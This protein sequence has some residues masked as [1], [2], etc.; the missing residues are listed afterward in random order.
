MTHLILISRQS[1]QEGGVKIAIYFLQENFMPSTKSFHSKVNH[2]FKLIQTIFKEFKT[3]SSYQ[4]HP[5]CM[6]AI[7][8]MTF[9]G[10]HF[11]IDSTTPDT[12]IITSFAL[13][14]I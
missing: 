9:V 10:P 2:T 8:L 5:Q 12:L 11:S 1:I 4:V 14:R 7:K 13:G 3:F 6:P